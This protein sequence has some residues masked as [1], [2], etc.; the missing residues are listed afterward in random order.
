MIAEK[1]LLKNLGV[2]KADNGSRVLDK[3]KKATKKQIKVVYE[4]EGTEEE[5]QERIDDIFDFIFDEV[6]RKREKGK[7]GY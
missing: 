2:K 3:K 4:C 1:E 7:T 6:M 5:N